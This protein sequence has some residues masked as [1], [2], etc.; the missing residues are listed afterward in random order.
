MVAGFFYTFSPGRNLRKDIAPTAH[1][2]SLVLS[3]FL[4]PK[5]SRTKKQAKSKPG[6]LPAPQDKMHE[7]SHKGFSIR[8]FSIDTP[9]TSTF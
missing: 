9:F 7:A 8:K 5:Y 3:H 2:R 1:F 6:V 4:A